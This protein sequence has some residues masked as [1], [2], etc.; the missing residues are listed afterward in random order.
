MHSLSGAKRDA[1]FLTH[2]DQDI[3]LQTIN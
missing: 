1:R 2:S 3:S